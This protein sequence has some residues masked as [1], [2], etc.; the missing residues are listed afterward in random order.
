MTH[1]S[2]VECVRPVVISFCLCLITIAL[3]GPSI[4]AG[5]ER[6]LPGTSAA[7]STERQLIEMEA[8]VRQKRAFE[9]AS[10]SR[11]H[12]LGV[13]L[14]DF[15][16]ALPIP[17][18]TLPAAYDLRAL[19][20]V[21]PAREPSG[22]GSCWTYAATGSLESF[23]SPFGQND[24]SEDHMQMFTGACGG[25]A[26][27]YFAT[28][29][30]AGWY[31]PVKESDFS[32]LSNVPQSPKVQTHVQR[33]L[34]LPMKEGA[35]DNDWTKYA[36]KELGGVYMGVGWRGL[37]N[38]EHNS[39]YH[40]GDS[41]VHAVTLVGW[42][43]NFDK[44]KFTYTTPATGTLTPPGNGA[45]IAKNN[46][47]ADFGEDGYYYLSY[48]DGTVANG[49][50]AVFTSEPAG[51]YNRI[52]QYDRKGMINPFFADKG[53]NV[54]TAVSGADLTAVGFY[55]MYIAR[56]FTIDIYK[57]PN[58]G[59]VHTGGPVASV[60]T[61]LPMGGFYTVRLPEKVRLKAG[62]KFSVVLSGTTASP[63]IFMAVEERYPQ[64]GP[65]D[66]TANPGE[67]FFMKTQ[68]GWQDLTSGYHENANLC[69]KAYT[70]PRRKPPF[71]SSEYLP[72]IRRF[73]WTITN[74]EN[75]SKTFK[76]VARLYRT[77]SRIPLGKVGGEYYLDD[78]G[79]KIR[80]KDGLLTLVPGRQATVFS[81][82]TVP[83]NATVAAY[84]LYEYS[85]YKFQLV[86]VWNYIELIKNY[87]QVTST[88]PMQ[89]Q[90]INYLGLSTLTVT[91]D[92]ELKAGPSYWA[93]TVTSPNESKFVFNSINGK[94][95][96]LTTAT[97]LGSQELGGTE[98][99]V[100]IPSGAVINT[101]NTPLEENYSFSF[102]VTGVN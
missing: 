101:W 18:G 15:Q 84:N 16:T 54:F 32:V 64:G 96:T 78:K 39:Y 98:W 50:G 42:D 38:P 34:Y 65:E 89:G 66:V 68:G 28:A 45:F 41:Q 10:L 79:R 37:T 55:N 87:P 97:P 56:D 44:S 11:L 8:A 70:S 31:G 80:M 63:E 29:Y 62:Q 88:M 14:K 35:L 36:I 85:K 82:L 25:G 90:N 52:Y 86:N 46:A 92:D 53:G 1:K 77:D 91:F 69:I 51:N 61:H 74:T 94:T 99:T 58:N 22:C 24:F 13:N 33:V 20:R 60:K 9:H 102:R 95:L 93:I 83:K 23:L 49:L 19:G 30:L 40:P 76:P 21:T 26:S 4:A 27:A 47:G 12:D 6:T 72:E 59:P 48:Y 75:S 43:D 2:S 73:K 7:V 17:P 5:D 67:S 57:D 71:M 81:P 3:S 100:R